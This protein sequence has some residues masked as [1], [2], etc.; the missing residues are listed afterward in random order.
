LPTC[1]RA[2]KECLAGGMAQQALETFAPAAFEAAE[3]GM[4]QAVKKALHNALNPQGDN[5]MAE[6]W[7][8]QAEV[9]RHG[10]LQ[11][12]RIES[13]KY[14]M[15]MMSAD[16]NRI[17]T[18]RQDLQDL[19]VVDTDMESQAAPDLMKLDASQPSGLPP[20]L[21]SKVAQLAKEGEQHESKDKFD[22]AIAA[23]QGVLEID[24]T[25]SNAIERITEIYKT[26]G[27]VT[28]AQAHLCAVAE[29]I[30]SLGDK[31]LAVYYLDKAEELLPGS[32]RVYRLTLGLLDVPAS[33]TPQTTLEGATPTPPETELL[34]A[35][36]EIGHEEPPIETELTVNELE[37]DQEDERVDTTTQSPDAEDAQ[38]PSLETELAAGDIEVEQEADQQEE[39]QS[40][41]IEA[42][43]TAADLEDDQEAA[44]EDIDIQPPEI[45]IEEEQQPPHET[46]PAATEQGTDQELDQ[47]PPSQSIEDTPSAEESWSG[48][49]VLDEIDQLLPDAPVQQAQEDAIEQ[50]EQVEQTFPPELESEP[51]EEV[52]EQGEAEAQLEQVG[53]MGPSQAETEMPQ[54][55]AE[56][57]EKDIVSTLDLSE[58]LDIALPSVQNAEEIN[59]YTSAADRVQT[60]EELFSA[61][62]DG[63]AATVG[64]DDYDTHYSLG[65]AYKEMMM[66]DHA[67]EEFK[68]AM[69]D[70]ER[71]LECCSMLAL[72]EK[73]K[74]DLNAAVNWL[75]L[76]I[77]DPG[78]PPT[79]SKGL[80]FD[81]AAL[82][83]EMGNTEESEAVLQEFR[84]LNDALE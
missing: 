82:L 72:C 35:E 11:E 63:V 42:E 34:A 20:E 19:G 41:P 21:V 6:Y 80:R 22:Q 74:G 46:E 75:R 4:G 7:L 51:Q 68:Q 45:G 79:D 3:R 59:D 23:Y 65:I 43:L 18:V 38:E 55:A 69:A 25:N 58:M 50:I 5:A 81:L 78:F 36:Q 16:D 28:K 9:A 44:Q 37:D 47:P 15:K 29:K 73:M 33:P 71:T 56:P 13:L 57:R 49:D 66:A 53:Q 52:E 2:L 54:S 70:P 10:G 83:E 76:G 1:E 60:A 17:E 32:T 64:G 26:S 24:P 30:A 77:N 48:K 84:D 67:I 62:R 12:D 8:L 27:T 61:F 14:A 40:P 31:E 39:P